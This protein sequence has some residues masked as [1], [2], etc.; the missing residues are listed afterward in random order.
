MR[1]LLARHCFMKLLLYESISFK[2]RDPLSQALHDG[3]LPDAGFADQN[4]IVFGFSGQNADYVAN[5]IIAP[6]DRVQLL[7]PVPDRQLLAKF[8]AVH[9]RLCH[10]EKEHL[11]QPWPDPVCI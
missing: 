8:P 7:L 5:F 6:D 10:G 11:F 4:R 9:Q 3:R 1:R 2:F